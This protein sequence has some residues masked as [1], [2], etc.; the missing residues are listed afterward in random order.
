VK[1]AGILHVFNE[2]VNFTNRHNTHQKPYKMTKKIIQQLTNEG[3]LVVDPCAGSF[4][5]LIACQK[6]K[7]N[8]LGT[9]LT[10]RELLRFNINKEN[11]RILLR[12][13]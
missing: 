7:R 2:L 9:D 10:L 6:L 4:V 5:S 13:G 11:S 12:K 3:D 1:D 8:F